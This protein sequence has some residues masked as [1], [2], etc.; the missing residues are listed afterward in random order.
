MA[1]MISIPCRISTVGPAA[2]LIFMSLVILAALAA[3]GGEPTTAPPADTPVP[4][5]PRRTPSRLRR[6]P[7]PPFPPW[8]ERGEDAA[9]RRRQGTPPPGPPRGQRAGAYARGQ[10]CPASSTPASPHRHPRLRHRRR[11][12]GLGRH[13]EGDPGAAP[14]A[15][16]RRLRLDG[17]P[18][19]GPDNYHTG[20][21]TGHHGLFRNPAGRPDYPH[22]L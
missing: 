1:S 11:R 5:L 22:V 10:R 3:C 17:A 6:R 2:M 12:P 21:H 19:A 20:Q 13:P 15:P 9:V 8:A 14:V 7:N 4:R 16:L 18:P